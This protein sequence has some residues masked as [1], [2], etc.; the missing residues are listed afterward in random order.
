[1]KKI[2]ALILALSFICIPAFAEEAEHDGYIVKYKNCDDFVVVDEAPM[3]LFGAENEIEYI[4]PDYTLE[5]LGTPGDPYYSGYQWNLKAVGADALWA[6][7]LYGEGVKIAVI[8]SG[9]TDYGELKDCLLPGKNCVEGAADVNDTSDPVGHGTFVSGIIAA[10]WNNMGIAGIAPKAKIVPLQTVRKSGTSYGAPTSAVLNAVD[11]AIN[12]FDCKILNMSLGVK[13]SVIENDSNAKALWQERIADAIEKGAILIAAVGNDGVATKMYPAAHEDVIGVGAV[14]KNA[15]DVITHAPYSQVNDSVFV[16]APGGCVLKNSSGQITYT[17]Y[18][19]S[20]SNSSTSVVGNSGTS[21]SAP[22]V[23]GIAALMVEK[24][25]QMNH[26]M[27][28]RD[29][30]LTSSDMGDDGYDTSYGH[31]LLNGRKM[32]NLKTE[33]VYGILDAEIGIATEETENGTSVRI[34]DFAKK[35]KTFGAMGI[36]YNENGG[37]DKFSFRKDE[38]GTI[39]HVEITCPE[40]CENIFIF[41]GDILGITK[42]IKK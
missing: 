36:S 38:G 32:A 34:F 40:N 31:G 29:L 3:A 30:M 33:E 37:L 10:A 20:I 26:K 12:E 21:F 9:V 27:F 42:T 2:F 1:M 25:P 13:A 5:L 15:D 17:D 23:A 16:V 41:E 7:E 22:T 8:D 4:I 39:G 6:E 14:Y 28:E 18:M 19:V 24:H 11:A 35:K